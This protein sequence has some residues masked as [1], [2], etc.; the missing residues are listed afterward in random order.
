MGKTTD[1]PPSEPARVHLDPN[2]VDSLRVLAAGDL[3]GWYGLGEKCDR[4]AA[5]AAL[6][7]SEAGPDG[8]AM[9]A[10]ELM[11]FRRYPPA[12]AA[13]H[14]VVVWL[15]ADA[16]LVV[17]IVQPVLPE[18]VEAQL[19]PPPETAASGLAAFHSQWIYADRGLTV[20]VHD[21]TG[22]PRRLYAYRPMSVEEFLASGLAAVETRRIPLRD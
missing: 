14:G 9:L 10:G 20:H 12:P 21:Y 4:R 8:A 1:D 17:E 3:R 11:A 5:E 2:C 16:I 13:P 7:P 15:E 18:P 22:E 6:G 19:G